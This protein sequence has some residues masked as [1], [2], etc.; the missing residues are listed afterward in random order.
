MRNLKF[1]K[2]STHR[3]YVDL[4][5]WTGDKSELEMVSGADDMLNY[6]SDGENEVLLSVSVLPFDGSDK[7]IFLE[8][9]NELGN[10][11]YYKLPI[12]RGIQID[13]IMWLCNVTKFIFADKFPPI[14]YFSKIN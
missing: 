10:G 7:L 14:L 2:E 8:E 4:P 12:Y 11:A 3:W 13:L 6:M 9:A 5:E 1:Y